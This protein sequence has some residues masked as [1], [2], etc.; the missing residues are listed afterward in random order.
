MPTIAAGVVMLHV[1]G[2]GDLRGDEAR[3]AARDIDGRDAALARSVDELVDRERRIGRQAE[4][5]LVVE[6]DAERP[7][8]SGRQPVALPDVSPFF[9]AAAAAPPRATFAGWVT[10]ATLPTASPSAA[11][12]CCGR[13]CCGWAGGLPIG[14]GKRIGLRDLRIPARAPQRRHCK[15][16]H[17]ASVARRRSPA[18]RVLRYQGGAAS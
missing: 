17:R 6:G 16:A 4:G 15:A 10:L 7:A 18:I 3:G 2:L 14:V 1:A 8:R 13:G 9:N 5:G 11:A 12:V